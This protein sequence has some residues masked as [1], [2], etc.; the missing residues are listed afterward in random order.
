MRILGIDPGSRFAG[1]GIIEKIGS[2]I[3]HLENGVIVLNPKLDFAQ[4]LACLFGEIQ[5]VIKKFEP[6]TMA[7]ED[8]FNHKNV[9]STLKL[10]HARG[11]IMVAAALNHLAIVEFTPLQVKQ[12]I[13][14]YGLAT[15]DQVQKMVKAL[16]KLPEVAEENASDALAVALCQAHSSGLQKLMV[17]ART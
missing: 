3:N 5:N 12:S 16:L 14:G 9:K 11:A 15:K 8:I 17:E 7:I 13:V 4:R 10:G 2:T 6:E 1:Y